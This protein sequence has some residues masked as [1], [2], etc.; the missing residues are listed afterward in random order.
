[1]ERAG[2]LDTEHA[3]AYRRGLFSLPDGLVYLDGNSLG[4]LPRAVPGALADVAER[5]WG[6]RLI[7]SWNEADWWGAPER[8]GDRIGALIGAAPGQVVVTDSTSVNLYKVFLAAAG[9]RST[10]SVVLVDPDSFPT[11]LYVLD[12]A[13]RLAGLRVERVPPQDV[14]SR[15]EENGSDVALV[16]YSSVDYRTGELWDLPS[17]TRAAHVVGALACWDLCHSAGVIDVGLDADGADFAV[18]CGYKYLNGG[19]GAPAFIYVRAEHQGHFESPLTGWHGHARPFAMESRFEPAPGITRARVGTGPMLSILALEAALS[20]YDG[21][22]V[23]AI[24]GRSLSLTRFFVECLDQLGIGAAVVTPR[25]DDR[26][27]SQI[28]VRHREA[29]A[30]VQALMGRGVVGDFREP[31]LVRLGFA[32]LYVSHEDAAV[33]AVALATV[34]ADEE[35]AQDEFRTRA[36]VT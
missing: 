30:V 33:A 12:G 23:G 27:G 21:V 28:A 14:V 2:A 16:A 7:R 6:E 35:Y 1:M 17:I 36:T 3:Q 25:E 19:P 9:M 18:G 4:A 31:D 34:L 10:R 20:A 8:V 5:Q 26:R 13:A 11:D 22:S 29:Y 32:P 15:L 24:R